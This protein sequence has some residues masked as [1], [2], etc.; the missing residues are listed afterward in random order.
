MN[1]YPQRLESVLRTLLEAYRREAWVAHP[2]RDGSPI[3]G[4]GP[5]SVGRPRSAP[6][7]IAV[8]GAGTRDKRAGAGS[9]PTP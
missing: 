7:H 4:Q 2:S 8:F 6:A 1:P 3:S 5:S 9:A